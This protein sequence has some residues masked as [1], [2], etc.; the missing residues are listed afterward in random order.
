MTARGARAQRR[1]EYRRRVRIVTEANR[2]LIP[3]HQSGH[4]LDHIVPVRYG[5]NHDILP[6]LI[7]QIDNLEWITAND[8]IGKGSR[9]TFRAISNLYRWGY[10]DLADLETLKISR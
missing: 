4:T 10:R 1:I 5:F 3:R 2:G 7:G 9:I 6:E 8:N